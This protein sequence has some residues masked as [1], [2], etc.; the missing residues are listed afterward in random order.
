MFYIP[1][2]A[3]PN[4]A[5]KQIKQGININV[6]MK[7]F[8][9]DNNVGL[10]SIFLFNSLKIPVMNMCDFTPKIKIP[11]LDASQNLHLLYP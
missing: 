8:K 4:Q 9:F 3:S 5:K 6:N 10:Q 1:N 2:S 11:G 7:P